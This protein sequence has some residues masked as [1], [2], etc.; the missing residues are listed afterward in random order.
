MIDKIPGIY[1]FRHGE[2]ANNV[3]DNYIAGRSNH[4]S[5]TEKGIDQSRQLGRALLKTGFNPDLIY[6]SPAKRARQTAYYAA[7]E[8]ST[9]TVKIINDDRLQEQ[10]T[11]QWTGRVATDIF[12]ETTLAA[13]NQQEKDFRSPGGESFNDVGA[14]MFDWLEEQDSDRQIA[15]F[16][17]GGAI[18]CLASYIKN[19]SHERT[20]KTQPSNTS[21]SLLTKE[22]GEWQVQY[23]GKNTEEIEA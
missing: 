8:L 2:A 7:L 19:W 13:I 17:H 21:V 16:T 10:D 12:T 18:R 23:I 11:G 6:S 9:P 1:L 4:L 15:A 20:Y 14:R 5:L 22:N 3:M